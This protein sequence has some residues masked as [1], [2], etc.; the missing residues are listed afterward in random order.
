M[1]RIMRV[2]CNN[3]VAK[4]NFAVTI[5]GSDNKGILLLLL[6]RLTLT[7]IRVDDVDRLS[8]AIHDAHLPDVAQVLGEL[9]RQTHDLIL[10]DRH[11]LD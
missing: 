4:D 9:G 2:L 5:F 1:I 8:D 10:T 7:R 3:C 6:R 11:D